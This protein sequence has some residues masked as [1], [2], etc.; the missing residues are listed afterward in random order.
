MKARR[1]YEE[2][3][4]ARAK[5]GAGLTLALSILGV[6]TASPQSTGVETVLRPVPQLASAASELPMTSRP[7]GSAIANDSRKPFG[8]K[9]SIELNTIVTIDGYHP[10]ADKPEENIAL[11]S[12]DGSQF[13][14]RA[15][16]GDLA[17][18]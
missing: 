15:R 5:L 11:F 14:V 10:K 2:S 7:I 17:T 3:A 1:L 8:V 12:P 9:E 4:I 6:S 13:L 16:R 18:N